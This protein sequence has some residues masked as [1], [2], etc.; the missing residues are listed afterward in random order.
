MGALP[1][2]PRQHKLALLIY[3]LALKKQRKLLLPQRKKKYLYPVFFILRGWGPLP[4]TAFGVYG[5]CPP[6]PHQIPPAA[7]SWLRPA[8]RKAYKVVA[9]RP[10]SPWFLRF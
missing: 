2:N 10:P 9:L 7:G 1:P 6:C 3:L 8:G 5:G 4:P